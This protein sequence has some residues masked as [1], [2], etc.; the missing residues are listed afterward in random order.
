MEL[1][2]EALDIQERWRLSYYDSLIV[3]AALSA[4]CTL[5]LTEELQ[6]GLKIRELTIENLF[7]I[8]ERSAGSPPENSVK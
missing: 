8:P 5:L 7:R 1:C 4:G 3:T 6:H 2:R